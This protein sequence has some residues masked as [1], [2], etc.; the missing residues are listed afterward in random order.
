MLAGVPKVRGQHS[1]NEPVPIAQRCRVTP[2]GSFPRR[3]AF[4]SFGPINTKPFLDFRP[5]LAEEKIKAVIKSA[6][7]CRAAPSS[8]ETNRRSMQEAAISSFDC[9]HDASHKPGGLFL[10]VESTCPRRRHFAA[11]C[12]SKP[13][14]WESKR[15]A[16]DGCGTRIHINRERH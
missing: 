11:Q 2:L 16:L 8:W 1:Y 7:A 9:V 5:C 15:Y 12:A 13:T 4:V 14:G 3:T 10:P 6:S